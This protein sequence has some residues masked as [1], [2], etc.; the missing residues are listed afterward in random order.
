MSL[1]AK[2]AHQARILRRDCEER[3]TPLKTVGE[4]NGGGI[5]HFVTI[6]VL[7]DFIF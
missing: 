1:F 6:Y 2:L 7:A 3:D 4:M 5:S